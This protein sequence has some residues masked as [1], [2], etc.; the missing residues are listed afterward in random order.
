MNTHRPL[1]LTLLL[2][3]TPL[4]AQPA[5]PTTAP[6]PGEA[7]SRVA[8]GDATRS[9]LQRQREGS[10]A[11]PVPRPIDGSVAEISH[12]RYLKSFQTELPQWFGSRLG[13]AS[14]GS[15]KE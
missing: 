15:A 1:L 13:D 7:A 4:W 8:V 6:A 11:S 5:A 9:L 2:A 12:Q 10:D 3:S 14:T